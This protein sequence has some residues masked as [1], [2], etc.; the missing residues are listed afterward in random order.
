MCK[1]ITFFVPIFLI[2][3]IGSLI[4]SNDIA[5]E[6]S[7][8]NSFEILESSE[9]GLKIKFSLPEYEL[10]TDRASRG[11][12]K[13]IKSESVT[14]A[15][16]PGVN[17]VPLYTTTVAIPNTGSVELEILSQETESINLPFLHSKFGDSSSEVIDP[18]TDLRLETGKLSSPAIIRDLR[19]VNLTLSPFKYNVEEDKLEVLKEVTYKLNYKQDRGNNELVRNDNTISSSFIPLYRSLVSNFD[20]ISDRYEIDYDKRLLIVYGNSTN[21]Q[22]MDKLDEFIRWKKQKGYSV[23]YASTQT[24]GTT[25]GSIKSYIQS[26]Y[27]NHYTRP[28]YVLLI[29]D[30]TGSLSIPCWQVYNGDSDYPFTQLAGGD[31]L[32]DVFIGR[33][34]AENVTDFLTMAEKVFIYERDLVP[35]PPAATA[36]YNRMLLVADTDPSGQSCQYVN[37]YARQVSE[38]VNP[39]YD[40]VELYATQPSAQTMTATIN[41]GVSFFNYRGHIN[42][43]YWD[44]PSE[45][46]YTNANRLPHCVINT[47]ATGNF[48]STDVSDSFV[49]FGSPALPKGGLTA[50]GMA[51]PSTHTMLNNVL[52]SGTFEGIFVHGMR[53]MSAPLLHSKWLLYFVYH[54]LLPVKAVEFPGWCNLMGDPTVEVFV[55]DPE[56]LSVQYRESVRNS[57]TVYS[58]KVNDA[59]G[60]DVNDACVTI[61]YNNTQ[62]IAYTNASGIATLSLPSNMNVGEDFTLTVSKHDFIPVIRTIDINAES[63]LR[64]VNANFNDSNSGNGDSIVNAGEQIELNVEFENISDSSYAQSQLTLTTEDSYLTVNNGNSQLSAIAAGNTAT[65]STPFTITIDSNTPDEH[66]GELIISDGVNSFSTRIEILNGVMEVTSFQIFDNNGVLNIDEQVNILLNLENTGS[67]VLNGIVVELSSESELVY[68][69]DGSAFFGN[70]QPGQTL[71][72]ITDGIT[73]GTRV[74][75]LTGTDVHLNARITDNNGYVQDREIVIAGST[76]GV[77]NPSGPDS[78]GHFIY[79]SSDTNWSDAPEYDWIEIATHQNGDGTQIYLT[80]TSHDDDNSDFVD[81]V[82]FGNAQLPFDFTFYGVDYDEVHIC[83]NGFISF[84]PT[85]LSTARNLPLPGPMTPDPIIAPFWDNLEVHSDG[86]VFHKYDSVNHIFIIEWYNMK[87]SY[88]T[89]YSE[90]FEIILYDPEYYPTSTGDGKVKIQYQ[91]FHDID[92]GDATSYTP[93][94]GQ[95]CTVGIGDHTGLDGL[96]YLFDQSYLSTAQPITN[97]CALIITGEP[98]VTI[99]PVLDIDDYNYS[100]T[101]GNGFIEPGESVQLGI[102]ITNSGTANA[103]NV[104]ATLTSTSPYVTIQDNSIESISVLIDQVVVTETGFEISIDSH[105]PLEQEIPINIS[106]T[107]GVDTWDKDMSLFVTAPMLEHFSYRISD[108]EDGN[109]NGIPNPGETFYFIQE[110]VNYG[111]VDIQD[112][113]VS[114]SS[115]NNGVVIGDYTDN[116]YRIPAQSST[117]VWFEITLPNNLNAGDEIQLQTTYTKTDWFADS[118]TA[119]LEVDVHTYQ[120]AGVISGIVNVD[121]PDAVVEDGLIKINNSGALIDENGYYKM[122]AGS[123]TYSIKALINHYIPITIEDVELT[124]SNDMITSDID[125]T[126][127]PLPI[128][129]QLNGVISYPNLT[130]TWQEPQESDYECLGFNVYKAINDSEY[131][132]LGYT[133]N[134]EYVD[135]LNNG[136]NYFYR[137]EAVYSIGTSFLSEV[138]TCSTGANDNNQTALVT[139]LNGNYPNPF[140]PVTNI[141]YSISGKTHVKVDIFNIRGQHVQSLV[142][143]IQPTGNY[144][145]SW[146]GLNKDGEECAS[147]LYLYKLETDNS[148]SMRKAMLIK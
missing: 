33:M 141:S 73:I 116:I 14:K 23:T 66:L 1:K 13:I 36:W 52:S 140:N 62:L 135:V 71:S 42:M 21:D 37:Y 126:P 43:S 69:P 132:L 88:N 35:M 7:N 46:E 136:E 32:G 59:D 40:Y 113:D 76:P 108:Y 74:E 89:S 75:F 60:N 48:G 77:G 12:V 79:H 145:V 2:F 16:I 70:A 10:Q 8:K 94:H 92:A 30:V 100:E 102:T 98:Y 111:N 130:L 81:I 18:L 143:E 125:F 20:L 115:D 97:N 54:D 124:V 129:N 93:G 144:V 28:D 131:S 139:K 19:V 99:A 44:M 95:Y 91:E 118:Y 64:I 96:T 86:G 104:T 112:I 63:V 101:N 57:D 15:S 142:N 31:D 25:T 4:A 87:N 117:Q 138:Y 49:R 84:V 114:I 65:N 110:V 133:E 90:T 127:V 72:N 6:N 80:D 17:E 58:V 38:M 103:E 146:E 26:K 148:I 55:G 24:T 22:Y 107:N 39:D 27:N 109:G 61:L 83:S 50:I 106:L 67:H 68:F 137:V 41:Q 45:G 78:F 53:D 3:W 5:Y 119:T 29:G 147:G 120:S 82:A 128:A 9:S 11:A 123:G 56:S 85:E 34:P 105:T 47:C 121:H 134:N 122:F 51:T